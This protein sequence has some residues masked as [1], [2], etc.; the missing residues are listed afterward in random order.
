MPDG[1][2]VVGSVPAC[3]GMG[4]ALRA[5]GDTSHPRDEGGE[6][7]GEKGGCGGRG[8]EKGRGWDRWCS[9]DTLVEEK[10]KVAVAFLV[11]SAAEKSGGGQPKARAGTRRLRQARE[12]DRCCPSMVSRGCKRQPVS[13]PPDMRRWYRATCLTRHL[14]FQMVNSHGTRALEE[15]VG[16]AKEAPLST[17]SATHITAA[18]C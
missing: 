13:R 7:L 1:L 9:R 14:C 3:A 10:P 4:W 8:L 6:G 11:A 17:A 5:V 2:G 12:A 16:L 18:T 15:V